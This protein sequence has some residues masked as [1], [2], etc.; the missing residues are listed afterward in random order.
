MFQANDRRGPVS[1]A[2]SLDPGP[3]PVHMSRLDQEQGSAQA[4]TQPGKIQKRDFTTKSEKIRGANSQIGLAYKHR[5]QYVRLES[6][7]AAVRVRSR[8]QVEYQ[9][10]AESQLDFNL[11]FCVCVYDCILWVLFSYFFDYFCIHW[12]EKFEILIFT[13]CWNFFVKISFFLT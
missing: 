4:R 12:L 8:L 2:L 10:T 1:P 9:A 11:V 6:T 5:F 13:K 3:P 7:I